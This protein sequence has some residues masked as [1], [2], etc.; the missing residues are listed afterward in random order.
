MY[1]CQCFIRSPPPD[2]W[3]GGSSRFEIPDLSF[4]SQKNSVEN[5]KGEPWNSLIS[6]PHGLV[7]KDNH[8]LETIKCLLNACP[9]QEGKETLGDIFKGQNLKEFYYWYIM[10][11]WIRLLKWS[12][13]LFNMLYKYFNSERLRFLQNS[14]QGLENQLH[15]ETRVFKTIFDCMKL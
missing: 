12:W 9:N 6:P 10:G 13:A 2:S 14:P 7:Y 3:S 4:H 5:G 1:S 15:S 8:V 11:K